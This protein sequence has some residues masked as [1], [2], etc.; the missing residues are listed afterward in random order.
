M[1]S[2]LLGQIIHDRWRVDTFIGVGGM[3]VVFKVWDIDRDAPLA[4]KV[5]QAD[6]AEDPLAFNLFKREA[7]ALKKLK[8]P[9]IVTFYGLYQDRDF[10]FLLQEYIDGPSLKD[11]LRQ[12][13]GKPLP[14]NEALTYLKTLSSALGYAHANRVV[15]CDVKPGNVLIDRGGK[16]YLTDFGIARHA[17]STITDLGVVGA[18]AYMAPEQI[19]EEPVNASTD[20]YALGVM[21]FEMLTGQRP[22][23]G[24]D[25]DTESAGQTARERIRYAHLKLPPP[26]P[27]SINPSIPPALAQ[28]LLKALAK[29]PKER[30][31]SIQVMF[32]TAR[33]AV[34]VAPGE[35]P[36]RV[37]SSKGKKWDGD[38]SDE[39]E[40]SKRHI[41]DLFPWLAGASGVFILGGIIL[42]FLFAVLLFFGVIPGAGTPTQ[43]EIGEIYS[44]ANYSTQVLPPQGSALPSSTAPVIPTDTSLPSTLTQPDP[45]LIYTAAAYTLRAELTQS[46]LLPTGTPLPLPPTV[47]PPPTEPQPQNFDLAFAS[48]RDGEFAVYLMNSQT[49]DWKMLDRP[50]GYE[51]VWWPSFCGDDLVAA[52]VQDADKSKPQWIYYLFVKEDRSFPL[53]A[54]GST[55]A[56]GVPRCRPS[57]DLDYIAYSANSSGA[58]GLCVNDEI[59]G[60]TY[61]FFPENGAITGYAA[62]PKNGNDFIFQVID[63]GQNN[64]IYRIK[65][66]PSSLDYSKIR[67]GGNP[68]ISPDGNQIAYSC[69]RSGDNRV[70][71]VAASDGS[72]QYTLVT[73]R[74]EKIRNLWWIQ[75]SSAWSADGR[76]IYFASAADGDYDI[77]RIRPDGSGLENITQSWSSNEI[78]PAI[79]W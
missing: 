31:E 9:N 7:N 48:D 13:R 45:A 38:R 8:H 53:N 5:L 75:P 16:I 10:H 67:G 20:V 42:I 25:S 1:S 49:E 77:Y 11:I 15:H 74:R 18:P 55:A 28:V 3:G 62:W 69:E 43:P 46:A 70:L 30:Y 17:D 61:K 33:A 56:L 51:R 58:W 4:M 79:Q 66:D 32:T 19:R 12:R 26:D 40:K 60:K 78:M 63:D 50:S 37:E 71:C 47:L 34:N 72:G 27:R 68:S 44:N 54:P 2:N 6:L 35:V 64:L 24:T 59:A 14:I 57:R 22:F 29:D 36:D 23:R 65:N 21:L 41:R 39:E 52:E 73:I 76:W